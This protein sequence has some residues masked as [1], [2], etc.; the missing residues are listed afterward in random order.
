MSQ[1][2]TLTVL[3]FVLCNISLANKIVSSGKM[4]RIKQWKHAEEEEEEGRA[5]TPLHYSEQLSGRRY[6]SAPSKDE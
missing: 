1:I 2:S 4:K 5:A 3:V 6:L